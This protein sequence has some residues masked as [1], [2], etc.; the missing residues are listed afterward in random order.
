M[1]IKKATLFRDGW[2]LRKG[3]AANF[4][5]API[6]CTQGV[7]GRLHRAKKRKKH[8]KKPCFLGAMPDRQIAA[9]GLEGQNTDLEIT[10]SAKRGGAK[11]GALISEGESASANCGMLEQVV[12]AWDNLSISAT[13]LILQMLRELGV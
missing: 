6:W 13:A 1:R 4:S 5:R 3:K 11:S 8:G 10:V 12:R 2:S 9:E 7:P